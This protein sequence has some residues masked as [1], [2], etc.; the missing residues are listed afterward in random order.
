MTQ[1]YIKIGATVLVLGLAFAGLFWSTLRDGT[2]YYKNL[3]E[4]M[5]NQSEWHGKQ[6]QLHGYVVPESIYRSRNNSLEYRFKVQNNPARATEPGS[7]ISVSYT[8]IVP[9]TFK[10]E[11]EV[12]LKGELTTEG[13]KVSPNGVMAKCPSKYEAA[14]K[15]GA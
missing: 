12:V 11:A 15:S 7:V 10:G 6:L 3:D 9:D 2:E 4:V 1:R 5:T 8:G 13:F 14:A